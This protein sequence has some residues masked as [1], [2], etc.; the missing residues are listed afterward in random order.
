MGAMKGRIVYLAGIDRKGDVED[1]LRAC[2]CSPTVVEIYEAS[3][4]SALAPAVI[5]GLADGSLDGVLHFSQRSAALFID[6]AASARLDVATIQH[7]CL[8]EDTA[9][10]LRTAG[11][12][13]LDVAE[14]PTESA[15][16]A[17]LE[18]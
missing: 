13:K 18:A 10:P 11:C 4:A 17:L 2:G 3:A 7:F 16:L 1:E 12:T 5:T 8:S 9:V 15:L 6:L 14:A